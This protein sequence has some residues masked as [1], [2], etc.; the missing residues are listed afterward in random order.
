MVRFG[1]HPGNLYFAVKGLALSLSQPKSI[2]GFKYFQ[3]WLFAWT[4]TI[5]KY[6]NISDQD[7]DIAGVDPNFDIH[8]ILP[9]DYASN[10]NEDIP[11]QKTK[12]QRRS[13]I[14]ALE[15]VI[16]EKST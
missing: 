14:K 5:L 9:E 3:F 11:T 7:F 4:N 1:I 12:A 6:Q 10:F 13:T 2:D 15:A 8:D 16:N